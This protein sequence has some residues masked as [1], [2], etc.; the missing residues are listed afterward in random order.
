MDFGTELARRGGTVSRSTLIAAGATGR[1]LTRAVQDGRLVRGRRGWYASPN[2]P[3]EVLTAFRIG[4]RLAATDAA[5]SHGLWVLR[6]PQLH[7]HVDP[8]AARMAVPRGVRLHWDATHPSDEPLRVSPT[9]ALLQ[10]GRVVGDEDLLVALESALEKRILGPDDLADLRSACP[11]RLHAL[12]AFARDDSQSGVETLTRW[13]LHLIGIVALAQV[14]LPGVG[15]VDL[16]IGRSLVIELDGRST[17]EFENDRR[18]DLHATADG[19]VTLRF[20]ATQILT[21]WPDV[22]R[23]IRAAIARGLHLL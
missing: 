9:H 8:H 4:G 22:E 10:L 11:Q 21:R 13:R 18:R 14:H 19:Y 12:F 1:D 16:L 5:R 23:A 6:S 17:H 3:P 20:S 7:V 15:R 2:L